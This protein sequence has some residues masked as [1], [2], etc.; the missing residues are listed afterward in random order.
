MSNN[1][2]TYD[3]ERTCREVCYLLLCNSAMQRNPINYN[4]LKLVLGQMIIGK[5]INLIFISHF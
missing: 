5:L 2:Y 3:D 1:N 4:N